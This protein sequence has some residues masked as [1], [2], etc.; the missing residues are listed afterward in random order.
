M[1]IN[2]KKKKIWLTSD[3]GMV[4]SAITEPLKKY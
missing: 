2:L 4:G 3:K 1:I